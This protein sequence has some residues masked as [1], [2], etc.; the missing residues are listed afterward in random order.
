M[1]KFHLA[2]INI[3]RLLAPL[4]DP[5]IA[6]FVALLDEIN[7]LAERSPGFVWRLQTGEGNATDLR[8]FDDDRIIVNM[9]VWESVEQL[10]NYVYHSAHTNVLKRRQEWFEKFDG[11]FLALWW[12]KAGHLPAVEEAKQRL[13]HL[14]KHGESEFAFSFKKTFPPPIL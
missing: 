5:L 10:K 9:S 4:D 3:G 12:V 2:Q 7:A 6:D 14:Y 1:P 13:D 8:P 11:A